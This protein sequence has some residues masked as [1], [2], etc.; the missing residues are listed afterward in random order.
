MYNS[1]MFILSILCICIRYY[2][3]IKMQK[4]STS[5]PFDRRDVSF[6]SFFFFI[7][8]SVN[9]A[10]C[11]STVFQSCIIYTRHDRLC[12]SCGSRK[13]NNFLIILLHSIYLCAIMFP[14]SASLLF[15]HSFSFIFCQFF[16]L[17]LTLG[18]TILTTCTPQRI[19]IFNKKGRYVHIYLRF[20]LQ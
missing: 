15:S 8:L 3:Q 14:L 16:S 12:F 2:R 18:A 13:F 6:T 10:S 4:N 20:H 19:D 17:S 5:R 1:F 11:I 9:H 7:I